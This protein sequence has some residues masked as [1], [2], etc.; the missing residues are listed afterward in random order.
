MDLAGVYSVCHVVQNTKECFKRQDDCND[1]DRICELNILSR[2][3]NQGKN[4]KYFNKPKNIVLNCRQINLIKTFKRIDNK[5]N[6]SANP[7]KTKSI[8]LKS[9]CKTPNRNNNRTETDRNNSKGF[10]LIGHGTHINLIEK[11]KSTDKTENRGRNCNRKR[12]HFDV[13][14]RISALK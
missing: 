8:C 5:P 4:A 7:N 13:I 1:A 12:S 11:F 2:Q 14:D 6:S 9:F 3:S 10:E